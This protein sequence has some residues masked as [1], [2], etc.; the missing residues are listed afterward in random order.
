MLF[1]TGY[2]EHH[3]RNTYNPT[4]LLPVVHN[5]SIVHQHLER[6]QNHHPSHHP[7]LRQRAL[8]HQ[9]HQLKRSSVSPSIS[10]I[11]AFV[12]HIYELRLGC[13]LLVQIGL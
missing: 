5:Y 9:T 13:R 3:L 8:C 10:H 6:I 2:E 12:L 7:L 4:D 11:V 1:P